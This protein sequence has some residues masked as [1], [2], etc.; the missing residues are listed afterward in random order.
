MLSALNDTELCTKNGIISKKETLSAFYPPKYLLNCNTIST[1]HIMKSSSE[2]EI[3]R[4]IMVLH[5]VFLYKGEHF[6]LPD[7]TIRFN[8]LNR[9]KTKIQDTSSQD[10]TKLI[11]INEPV[12]M[13]FC[14]NFHFHNYGTFLVQMVPLIQNCLDANIAAPFMLC[15]LNGWQKNILNY[16]FGDS[17][18]VYPVSYKCTRPEHTEYGYVFKKVYVPIG[19]FIPEITIQASNTLRKH[20]VP[21]IKNKRTYLSRLNKKNINY[22]CF[23][24]EKEIIKILKDKKFD[25]VLPETLSIQEMSNLMQES[26]YVFGAG[27]SGMFNVALC[28]NN[29]KILSVET[30]WIINGIASSGWEH[31]HSKLFSYLI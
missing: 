23:V 19:T 18:K 29:T 24:N 21:R 31:P 28:S 11:T 22:R 7:E 5:D 12:C 10:P 25:I 1:D 30:P 9:E 26:E 3:E 15:D 8:H 13:V 16:Y 17:L 2:R 4:G 27:G 6:I 20:L 14:S